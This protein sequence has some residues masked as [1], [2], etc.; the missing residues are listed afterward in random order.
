MDASS[1]LAHYTSVQAAA[2]KAH[3]GTH[4]IEHMY[5]PQPPHAWGAALLLNIASTVNLL[6]QARVNNQ[7]SFLFLLVYAISAKC[8]L[9]RF[10]VCRSVL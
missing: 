1:S 6:T 10:R 5:S 2:S 3:I 8:S 9:L 4:L 7:T